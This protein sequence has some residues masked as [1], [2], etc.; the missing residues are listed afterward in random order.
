MEKELKPKVGLALSGSGSKLIFYVGFLEELDK[1]GVP[2]HYIAAMSGASIAAAAYAC[3]RLKEFKELAFSLT[4]E[5]IMARLAPGKGGLYS[6]DRLEEW[7]REEI[8]I[9]KKMEDARPLLGFVAADIKSGKQVVLSMGDIARAGRVSCTLPFFF[10]PVQWGG[11]VLIDGGLLNVIPT[12]VVKDAGMDVII[13]VNM[14]GTR[15]LFSPGQLAVKKTL[16][17]FKKLLLLEYMERAWELLNDEE[18]QEVPEKNPDMFSVLGKSM[19]IAIEES[20][21]DGEVKYECDL[22][23]VPPVKG[24]KIRDIESR[25]LELYRIG[26]QCGQEYAP[27]ILKIIEEKAKLKSASHVKL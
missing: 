18:D 25:R 3:G 2:I 5:K 26:Q 6:L 4:K 11:K 12:D 1:A 16:N 21:K 27:K 23:I 19:D 24:F 22:M 17:V 13:G 8:T 9:G 10:E 20:E 7:A 15:H 14:R